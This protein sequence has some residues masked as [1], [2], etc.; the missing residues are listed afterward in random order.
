VQGCSGLTY[1]QIIS[2]SSSKLSYLPNNS[3]TGLS[4]LTSLYLNNNQITTLPIGIFDE[5]IKLNNLE[6]HNNQL[7]TLPIGI[8]DEL[9]GLEGISLNNNQLTTLPSG[10]FYG[11]SKVGFA[12]GGGIKLNINLLDSAAL[13]AFLNDFATYINTVRLGGYLYIDSGRTSASDAAVT[14]ITSA[15]YNWTIQEG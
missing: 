8:F 5:L 4:S 12:M 7:T 10:L 9:V 1:L 11:L 2:Y 6:L 3:F 14:T 15:P 13:D